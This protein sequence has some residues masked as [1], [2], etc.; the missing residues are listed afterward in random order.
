MIVYRSGVMAGTNQTYVTRLMSY[1][2]VK[3]HMHVIEIEL[4][5]AHRIHLLASCVPET[6]T[7][8]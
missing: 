6:K 1:D 7:A 2:P 4:R 3:D 8:D 5:S